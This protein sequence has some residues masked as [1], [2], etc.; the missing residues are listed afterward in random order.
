MEIG[1]FK[2]R[3][4]DKECEL[5]A[6]LA[7][8]EAE[9]RAS[10]EPEVG[11]PIDEATSAGL[12][13][14]VLAESSLDDRSL[15]LVRDALER[16]EHGRFGACIDCGRPIEPARLEALPWTPYCRADQEKHDSE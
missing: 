11:D 1:R 12:Q 16:I 9:A 8:L 6:D 14:A 2:H 4:L 15:V 13:A 3:L 5:Q 10:G 7:R